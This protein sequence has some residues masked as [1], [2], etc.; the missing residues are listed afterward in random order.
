MLLK[1]WFHEVEALDPSI[2]FPP[3]IELNTIER[4]AA[5]EAGVKW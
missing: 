5:C 1:S 3:F 4:E 2:G